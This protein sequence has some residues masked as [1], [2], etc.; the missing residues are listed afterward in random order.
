MVQLASNELSRSCL[1]TGPATL[2]LYGPF[3]EDN[4]SAD[5]S[6]LGPDNFIVVFLYE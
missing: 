4:S 6:K 3:E 1:E 5:R 2:D